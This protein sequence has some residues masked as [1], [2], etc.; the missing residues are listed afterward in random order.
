[1]PTKTLIQL[2]RKSPDSNV[3]SESDYFFVADQAK[4]ITRGAES[5]AK[6]SDLS[7]RSLAGNTLSPKHKLIYDHG[8]FSFDNV[9]GSM[10]HITDRN[11]IQSISRSLVPSGIIDHGLVSSKESNLTIELLTEESLLAL[12]IAEDGKGISSI[13]KKKRVRFSNIN[14]R[15]KLFNG[16][17]TML[18]APGKGGKLHIKVP[19]SN[20]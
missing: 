8:F 9:I 7:V 11:E 12:T 4:Q 3:T 1:M 15:V 14:N 16:N 13:G 10:Y 5:F 6:I 18:P 2:S 20:P 17:V 19:I